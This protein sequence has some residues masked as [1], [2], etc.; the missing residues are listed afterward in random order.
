VPSKAMLYSFDAAVGGFDFNY[1]LD[2]IIC[3]AALG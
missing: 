1:S 2:L 3:D